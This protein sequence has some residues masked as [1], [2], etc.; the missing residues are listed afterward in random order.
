MSMLL[1]ILSCCTG[2]SDADDDDDGENGA[3]NVTS[4]SHGDAVVAEPCSDQR[5]IDSCQSVTVS[6]ADT[7]ASRQVHQPNEFISRKS[8]SF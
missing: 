8:V 5:V 1:S 6:T 7:S 2:S 3:E 4:R